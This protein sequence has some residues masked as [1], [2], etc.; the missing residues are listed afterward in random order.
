MKIKQ[1]LLIS[2]ISFF[3]SCSKNSIETPL[4]IDT[5]VLN[6]ALNIEAVP[7]SLG[8]SYTSSF[9]R[10]T[11]VTTPNGG[12]IHIVAQKNITNEQIVRCRSILEHFLKNLS[13]S[14]HGND[15]S[16]IANQMAANNATLTLLNG[17]DDGS[18]PVQVNGQP[19]YENEIQVEGHSWYTNQDY[20]HRDAAYEEILH[21]VH[22][23]GIGVDGANANPGAA[24][25]FQTE[26]RAAQVNA[27]NDNL[28]GIGAA[29]WIAELTNENS[30]S[31]E[32]LAA[33]IDVYYGLWGASNE[34][35]GMNGLY[36]AKT[37]TDIATKDPMGQNLLNN[38]FFHPYITY[39]ARIDS[40]FT[41]TFSLKYDTSKLYTNHSRYL[42]EITLLG[43]S[44]TNA[45]V[46]E[47]NNDI[48]GNKG[49]NT[50]IFSGNSSEYTISTSSNITTVT[51]NNISRDGTNTLRSI[52]KLQFADQT[53]DL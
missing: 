13:S 11:R 47:L 22:D 46:N 26:I 51:D 30:L 1:V 32:Y 41:G 9:N 2:F 8:A 42:K 50:V 12:A 17:Q 28:W 7:A 21:L 34:I 16:S 6:A 3:F 27:L 14:V 45:H 24:T 48:T 25:A 35:N 36:V 49:I 5:S 20:N 37:R 40:T 10:Y 44:N 52:E 23:T 15:K 33:V 18:N 53:I 19:L 29:S 38:K 43:S 4:P 39:N 31:Q